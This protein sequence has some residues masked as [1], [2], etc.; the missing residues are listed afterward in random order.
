MSLLC[1]DDSYATQCTAIVT[2]CAPAFSIGSQSGRPDLWDVQ[3]SQTVLYPEGANH[4]ITM[5]GRVWPILGSMGNA[6]DR[7][8][9]NA[10]DH[11]L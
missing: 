6:R 4:C 7:S 8:E 11:V 5:Q 2:A 10:A 1:Q 3:L 9:T